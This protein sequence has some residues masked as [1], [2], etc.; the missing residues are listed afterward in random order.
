MATEELA[1]AR[2]ERLG[3]LVAR[4]PMGWP[5]V[6]WATLGILVAQLAA[7]L[8]SGLGVDGVH[9]SVRI[10]ARTSVVLFIG[11]FS[12]SSL[13]VL[14]PGPFTRWMRANRRQIGVSFAISHLVHLAGILTLVAAEP[15]LGR[16]PIVLVIG[17]LGF[18]AVLA[19]LATSFD[20]TTRWLGPRRWRALHKTG[21]WYLWLVFLVSYV[22]VP[23]EDGGMDL[24]RILGFVLVV[25]GLVVRIAAWQ[26]SRQI[27]RPA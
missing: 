22:P 16:P 24:I 18:V 25:G 2:S 21:I 26:R 12:A 8:M 20:T 7:L 3:T 27:R 14:W 6:G 13:V 4:L 17:G 9:A 5:V 10:S 11:A 15:E 19:M 23:G 1:G